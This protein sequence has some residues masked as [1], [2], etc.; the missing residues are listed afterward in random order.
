MFIQYIIG[1]L[2]ILLI[3]YLAFRQVFKGL[4][5]PPRL[6]TVFVTTTLFLILI[7]YILDLLIDKGTDKDVI[8]TTVTSITMII[9]ILS[10]LTTFWFSSKN[11]GITRENQ[12]SNFV[13][14]LIANNY[15]ILES[16]QDKIDELVSYLQKQFLRNGYHFDALVSELIKHI[17]ATPVFTSL[18]DDIC[19]KID[20]S[21]HK[22]QLRRLISD[23][24]SEMAARLLMTF[25]SQKD[26]Y[27]DF[28]KKLDA[29]EKKKNF[30][31]NTVELMRGKEG[32]FYQIDNFMNSYYEE[33]VS[34]K[35]DYDVI[36]NIC[37]NAFDNH[38]QDI[39][40]F[41]R[42][43]YR[44][45]KFINE[46]YKIDEESRKKFLGILRSQ[47]SEN[48]LLGIYYNSAFT[49]KGMGYGK[50]LIG[51]DFFGTQKD[52]EGHQPIHFRPSNLIQSR[53]DIDLMLKVFCSGQGAEEL[54]TED[55]K[56]FKQTLK[57]FYV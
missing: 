5:F 31:G 35:F 16:K 55:K 48:T 30:A 37:N 56:N 54:T 44:V 11:A 2:L 1:A 3:L 12:N 14:T 15:K 4:Q 53:S 46:Q 38:Y 17:K 13:M 18:I 7:M 6:H 22:R 27:M 36:S 51:L 25:L 40:H 21:E 33:T 32:L 10:Y 57:K 39:G 29:S 26:R 47:Y 34:L 24:D 52:L 19:S 41:F 45:V 20:N 28:Y 43:S 42:N 9:A 23:F 49:D 8:R 50:E